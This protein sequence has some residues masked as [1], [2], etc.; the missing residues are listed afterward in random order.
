[1][2]NTLFNLFVYVHGTHVVALG[3]QVRQVDADDDTCLALLQKMVPQDALTATRYTFP[4]SGATELLPC[5]TVGLPVRNYEAMKMSGQA[6][7]LFEPIFQQ[8]HAEE[9]PLLCLTT[10]QDGTPINDDGP[11]YEGGTKESDR[12]FRHRVFLSKLLATQSGTLQAV[13]REKGRGFFILWPDPQ[14]LDPENR[15]IAYLKDHD[16]TD[17]GPVWD[18]IRELLS[19]YD[20]ET[21]G[22]F[23]FKDAHQEDVYRVKLS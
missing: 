1:M 10:V 6:L 7:E 12:R 23:L 8:H 20:A 11:I 14:T 22:I 2:T 21:Q 17:S 19:I 16:C 13:A 5:G 9:A 3:A 15:K 18:D 4:A